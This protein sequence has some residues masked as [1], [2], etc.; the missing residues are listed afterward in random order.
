[1]PLIIAI[2]LTLFILRMLDLRAAPQVAER[3]S[4]N[5]IPQAI[6]LDDRSW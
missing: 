2:V 1:M 5:S 4:S 3:P 6:P